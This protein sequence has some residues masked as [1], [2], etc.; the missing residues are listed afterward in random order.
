MSF[1]LLLG[2]LLLSLPSI[3]HA[4]VTLIYRKADRKVVAKVIPPHSVDQELQNTIRSQAGGTLDDYETV[5]IPSLPRGQQAIVQ[6]DGTVTLKEHPRVTAY[7]QRQ[8]KVQQELKTLGLS[9]EA[10]DTLIVGR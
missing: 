1:R 9:Q 5:S 10:I 8:E 2:F 6:A 3:A 7:K 4:E